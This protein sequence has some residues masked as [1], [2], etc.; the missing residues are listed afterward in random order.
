ME[1]GQASSVGE[2]KKAMEKHAYEPERR[3][4]VNVPD[5][6]YSEALLRKALG[7]SML[8]TLRGWELYCFQE[9]PDMPAIEEFLARRCRYWLDDCVHDDYF[10]FA[11]N[12]AS[13]A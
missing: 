8:S 2:M 3:D 6:E 12:D 4:A 9:T 7:R 13:A 5:E 11:N 10:G 1:L